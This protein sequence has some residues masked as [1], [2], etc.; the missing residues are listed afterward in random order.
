[1]LARLS[2]E[3]HTGDVIAEVTRNLET[4]S[5]EVRQSWLARLARGRAAATKRQDEEQAA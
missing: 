3:G 4:P 1:M 5:Q 2:A